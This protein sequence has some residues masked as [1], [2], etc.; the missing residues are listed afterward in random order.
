MSFADNRQYIEDKFY[1]AKYDNST[2]IPSETIRTEL[3]KMIDA[4]DENEPEQLFRARLYAYVLDNARLSMN[5][6]TP[7]PIMID[8]GI[9]YS[10]FASQ[11]VYSDVTY[12]R[13]DI[14]FQKYMPEDAIIRE[15]WERCG[16]ASMW[17]DFWHTVPDWNN[18]IKYGF[19][20]IL[21][22]AEDKKKSLLD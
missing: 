19:S 3:H 5:T 16:L 20:G 10:Y 1:K 9:D 2:G 7:F 4:K 11:P 13:R 17:N 6:K 15:N 12:R 18:V 14:A 22:N 8:F 21:K